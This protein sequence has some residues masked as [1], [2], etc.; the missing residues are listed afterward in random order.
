MQAIA[1]SR[2]LHDLGY[3]L[4]VV[5]NE[6][7]QMLWLEEAIDMVLARLVSNELSM[8][9]IVD[10]IFKLRNAQRG[11]ENNRGPYTYNEVK[12]CLV[13]FLNR[14]GKAESSLYG[15]DP[16]GG[17]KP[18]SYEDK[19]VAEAAERVEKRLRQSGAVNTPLNHVNNQAP[20]QTNGG[21]SAQPAKTKEEK[22]RT[23]CPD[24]N[25]ST[26][27]GQ[28]KGK[29]SKG[30]HLCSNSN[31]KNFVCMRSHPAFSCRNPAVTK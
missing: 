14:K 15:I 2:A 24:Y 26:G 21:G 4:G 17:R 13:Q 3:F 8:L 6:R 5:E 16:Y 30:K 25:S 27:C 12:N 23:L 1:L 7:Q 18:V 28:E 22:I 9:C 31:H 20:R 10:K 11:R 19:M 29:C